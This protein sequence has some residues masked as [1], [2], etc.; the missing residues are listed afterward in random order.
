MAAAMGA[1]TVDSDVIVLV[2]VDS[3]VLS[4]LAAVDSDEVIVESEDTPVESDEVVVESDD[5]PVDSDDVAVESEDVAVESEDTPVEMDDALVEAEVDND[6]TVLF[7]VNNCD[8]LIASLL[9]AVTAPG[10]TFVRT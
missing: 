4:E 9:V 5:T 7:V 2:V 6:V 3:P 1:I 10:A 8:P